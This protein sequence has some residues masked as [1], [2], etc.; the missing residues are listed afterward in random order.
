VVE[1]LIPGTQAIPTMTL[2][3]IAARVL[4]PDPKQTMGQGPTVLPPRR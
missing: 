3:W 4:R 2:A 1:S